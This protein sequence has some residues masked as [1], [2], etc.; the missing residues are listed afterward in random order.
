MVADLIRRGRRSDRG[1]E[2]GNIRVHFFKEVDDTG[3]AIFSEGLMHN[4]DY[5][6][7]Q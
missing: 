6:N 5:I 2:L 4:G 7:K 1:S 3:I